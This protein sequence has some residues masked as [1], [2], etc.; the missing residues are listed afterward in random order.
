MWLLPLFFAQFRFVPVLSLSVQFTLVSHCFHFFI[1][2]SCPFA[3]IFP[4][5]GSS[6]LNSL[7]IALL[8]LCPIR[9]LSRTRGCVL[10]ECQLHLAE[11]K[12]GASSNGGPEWRV[13]RLWAEIPES[14]WGRRWRSG[15]GGERPSYPGPAGA[16]S[17]R[18]A[19]EMELV[20][21]HYCSLH[22]RGDWTQQPCC[23]L[24]NRRGR[25]AWEPQIRPKRYWLL[26]WLFTG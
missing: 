9:A 21:H 7:P 26:S 11:S 1:L 16:D 25:W 12:L 22:R 5:P 23:A 24:Q 3:C 17:G 13:G 2:I 19:G 14:F 15:S 4:S 20:Q 10:R 18:G 6:L 8:A